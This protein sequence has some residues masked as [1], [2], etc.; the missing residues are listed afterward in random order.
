MVAKIPQTKNAKKHCIESS[1]KPTHGLNLFRLST[2]AA[3]LAPDYPRSIGWQI[4]GLDFLAEVWILYSV[5]RSTT[6]PANVE[7]IVYVVFAMLTYPRHVDF[8]SGSPVLRQPYT[9]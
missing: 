5:K 1:K 3:F 6:R 9:T 4:G 8:P 2:I 7:F